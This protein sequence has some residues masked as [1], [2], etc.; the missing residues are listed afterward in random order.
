VVDLCG[1]GAD[2]SVFSNTAVAAGLVIHNT[3]L[4]IFLLQPQTLAWVGCTLDYAP[5]PT[6]AEHLTKAE[7]EVCL[8]HNANKAMV[9]LC[10]VCVRACVCVCVWCMCC[11][12]GFQVSERIR[13][14]HFRSR[15]HFG[16]RV[17]FCKYSIV[18]T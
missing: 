9:V 12:H 8:T 14:A 2:A 15:G 5:A 18:C 11:Y 3:L 1:G 6:G 10:C 7:Y 4:P 16:S 13:N 17:F